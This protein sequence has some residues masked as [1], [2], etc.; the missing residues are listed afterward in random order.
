MSSI[1]I[2][3]ILFEFSVIKE[4]YVEIKCAKLSYSNIVIMT[5]F[6]IKILMIK[7]IKSNVFI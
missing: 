3:L 1:S 6:S 2:I 7:D 4:K 5:L